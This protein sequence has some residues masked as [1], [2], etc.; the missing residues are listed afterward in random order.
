[1]RSF[2]RFLPLFLLCLLFLGLDSLGW[3]KPVR[4]MV[5]KSTNPLKGGIYHQVQN[6]KFKIQSLRSL[7]QES[8]SLKKKL[9][10][11]EREKAELKIENSKLKIDNQAMRRLLQAPL[12]PEWRF[13]AAGVIGRTRYLTIDKGR[14]E[15]V[16]KG[17][18]V[19]FEN[20]LVGR[21]TQVSEKAAKIILPNDSE[22]KIEV[23]IRAG[24]RESGRVRGALVG[25]DGRLVL[26]EV[27]QGERI[28]VD[29]LVVTSG[30]EEIFPPNLL[31][32]KVVKIEKEERQPYQKA[33]VEPLVDYD[34]L[35][36]V[37]LIIE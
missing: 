7:W 35:E 15:G 37:F 12:P 22:S 18:V 19:V 2:R 23:E 5:E 26:T 28:E 1:M 14:R 29:D 20:V 36:T 31:I 16:K 27:L 8:E 21:V 6:S 3:T 32:G 30:G 4:G 33:E 24:E 13:L 10:E 17:M 25:E 11:L 9:G 34:R